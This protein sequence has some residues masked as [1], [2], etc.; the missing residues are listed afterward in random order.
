MRITRVHHPQQL[1]AGAEVT[2]SASVSRHL[3]KVLRLRGGDQ[4]TL[5]NA[6]EG[7]YRAEVLESGHPLVVALVRKKLR[8]YQPPLLA[9]SLS[10]ALSRGDRMDYAIQKATELGVIAIT[11]LYSEFTEVKFRDTTRLGKKLRHWQQIAEH[12]AEQSGRLDV[13]SI[14]PPQDF[15]DA[16]AAVDTDQALVFEASGESA[17]KDILAS[18]SVTLF[19]GPEGGFSPEEIKFA[20]TSGYPVVRLGP[21]ILRAETAPLVALAVL[22]QLYG[23]FSLPINS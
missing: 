1:T 6:K 2:L 4:V 23:D 10:L 12:A 21:R 8:S 18:G 17:P 9:L 20:K 11:P 7:E 3:I 22:Q 14:N 15:K 13:P 5:F 19:T 16:I